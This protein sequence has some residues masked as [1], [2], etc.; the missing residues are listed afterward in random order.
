MLL[1]LIR[2]TSCFGNINDSSN[3]DDN[4]DISDITPI[5]EIK[6][7]DKLKE[8]VNGDVSWYEIDLTI[9]ETYELDVKLKDY[10]GSDYSIIYLINSSDN[11]KDCIS[12]E[13]NIIKPKGDAKDKD[14]CNLKV[15]VVK[16]GS[17]KALEIKNIF[18]TVYE[19]KQSIELESLE[20]N[21]KVVSYGGNLY[22]YA[23]YIFL[24]QENII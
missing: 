23:I 12:L 21:V 10:N 19:I 16:N 3:K 9:G 14:R 6:T 15:E 13:N 22:D 5:L 17:I 8:V 18:I 1:L 24:W 7:D 20:E 4:N 11:Y 2:L